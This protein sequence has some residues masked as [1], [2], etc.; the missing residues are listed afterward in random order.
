MSA[1]LD[2]RLIECEFAAEP[3]ACECHD[4]EPQEAPDDPRAEEREEEETPEE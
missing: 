1:C 3:C 2:C 4:S